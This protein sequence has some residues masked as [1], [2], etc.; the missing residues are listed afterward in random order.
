MDVST[1]VVVAAEVRCHD[2]RLAAT[3]DRVDV[4]GGTQTVTVDG[5]PEERVHPASE[6]WHVRFLAPDR[7]LSDELREAASYE[8]AIDL[9]RAYAARLTEH[10]ESVAALADA[11]K[12]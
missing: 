5:T 6:V 4:G 3:V 7:M 11:L 9:G 2:G 10:A 12:I 8:E 1:V